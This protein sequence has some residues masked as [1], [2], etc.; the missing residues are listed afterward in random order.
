M[1]LRTSATHII[2][3]VTKGHSLNDI[4][5]TALTCYP[6]PRDQR[7]IQALSYGVCRWYHRLNEFLKLLLT[8]PLKDKD[9]DIHCLLLVGLYQLLEMR[10]PP[11]A[12]VAETVAAAHDFKKIWAKN[13][14]NAILR[15]FIRRQSEFENN[16][17]R[18][19]MAYYSHPQWM[20]EKIK[21]NWPNDWE[22]I[23]NANN[24]Y[25]PFS[26]RVN[27]CH[28]TR[29]EYMRRLPITM[30]AEVIPFTHS[31]ITL[32]TPITIDQLPGF[33]VGDVSVQDGAAQ[34]AAELLEVVPTHRI[35]DACAAPGGKTTHLL[36]MVSAASHKLNISKKYELLAID[37]DANRLQK[38]NENILRL[39]L[40]AK[41]LVA[42][43][44]DIQGWWD[45]KL[46]DRI[47]LDAPCSAS[48]VIRRHP[49]IKLLRRD[50]DIAKL[51]AT[52]L[53]LLE[54]LWEVLAPEGLLVY[55]TCSVFS[56]ENT[57]VMETFLTNH[58][59]VN[60][61]KISAS[62]GRECR[63]G[64]QILPGMEGMDGFYFARLRK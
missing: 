13:L 31:G 30:P 44:A 27:Q 16:M 29:D 15:N 19:E 37:S 56:E 11:H 36:E 61:E 62:W 34:L 50:T 42:D 41:C 26:L 39:K 51:V 53:H 33:D 57:G 63:V 10:I 1:N 32:T 58:P 48:G 2:L 35:L 54:S 49:D 5:P 20:I 3:Q 18:N 55:A 28:Y 7:L 60:E 45:G 40:S 6:D 52:Q 47:L 12:A 4:L 9:Q 24:Q 43:A 14:V 8:K 38:I 23:L 22:I 59:S 25:P 21:K 17:N 64:R 46:F